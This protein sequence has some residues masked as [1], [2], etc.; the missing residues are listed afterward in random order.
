MSNL[1]VKAPGFGL[2]VHWPFCAAKCPYCDF[3]SHVR[4]AVDDALWARSLCREM[5]HVTELSGG[6]PLT[7]I[8]FG[9]G[10]PSLMD[11]RTVDMVINTAD[12]LWGCT[13]DVEIT[14]EANPTSVEAEKFKGFRTAGVNRLSIGIQALNDA[15]LKRLGR[16][17]SVAE[18]MD[19]YDLARATFDRV[20]FDL[21]YARQ[22][23]TPEGARADAR[24]NLRGRS[25]LALPAYLGARHAL[26]CV[27]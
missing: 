6:G 2:Y 27:A 24:T 5:E 26:L 7:S 25:P 12:R 9:G 22:G 13:D 21:I 3:N 18:A 8:F 1:D 16:L 17:H 20:S 10:T 23:Q 19:A 14:L 15:D 11:P 4:G